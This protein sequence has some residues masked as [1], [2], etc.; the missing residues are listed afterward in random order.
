MWEG[1]KYSELKRQ[2][3]NPLTEVKGEQKKLK[4]EGKRLSLNAEWSDLRQYILNTYPLKIMNWYIWC[5]QSGEKKEGEPRQLDMTQSSITFKTTSAGQPLK[6]G[7]PY[8]VELLW[9]WMPDDTPTPP[10]TV[11]FLECDQAIS[12]AEFVT[13]Q[14]LWITKPKGF[15]KSGMKPYKLHTR[16]RQ[17]IIKEFNVPAHDQDID[18]KYEPESEFVGRLNIAVVGGQGSAKTTFINT[19][20]TAFKYDSFV[21]T[22]PQIQLG[23]VG[24]ST[25]DH[26]TSAVT[27]IEMRTLSKKEDV[28]KTVGNIRFID[29]IGWTSTNNTNSKVPFQGILRGNI[30]NGWKDTWDEDSPDDRAMGGYIPI[31]TVEDR[32]HGCIM[33]VSAKELTG[34]DDGG[35]LHERLLKNKKEAEK[36][37]VTPILLV[38]KVDIVDQKL[39]EDYQGLY[40]S[41]ELC[42]ILNN[43]KSAGFTSSNIFFA[44]LYHIGTERQAIIENTAMLAFAAIIQRAVTTKEKMKKEKLKQKP[45][46]KKICPNCPDCK[47]KDPK[48]QSKYRHKYRCPQWNQCKL[49]DDDEDHVNDFYHPCPSGSD[50]MF[51]TGPDSVDHLKDYL[52]EGETDR[53][54]E[55]QEPQVPR[56][57]KSPEKKKEHYPT[58]GEKK[59]WTA[60]EVEE[61]TADEVL[62]WLGE[63]GITDPQ[64]KEKFVKNP[65]DGGMLLLMNDESLKAMG[66]EEPLVR[67]KVLKVIKAIKPARD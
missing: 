64:I 43:L 19:I 31:P 49:V 20:A 41:E 12:W 11:Y 35:P 62:T 54:P 25:T 26:S 59:V 51:L 27:H 52:H 3:L 36:C 16:L 17:S 7:T 60:E 34:Y 22:Q 8:T 53:Q 66:I 18:T 55:P 5:Y 39:Q 38:T 30:P 4:L 28:K 65:I 46:E 37:G 61:W 29:T 15:K 57:R 9:M 48:H 32:V 50:C 44:Q 58:P 42:N 24:S 47:L 10:N 21:P 14:G 45:D 67:L 6:P 63:V 40:E 2:S 13:T 56:H 33:F 23:T 1:I